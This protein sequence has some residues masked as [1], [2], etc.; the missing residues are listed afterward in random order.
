MRLQ[1]GMPY[2][3]IANIS[4]ELGGH[5]LGVIW[6]G[7]M[8]MGLAGDI[9]GRS[10]TKK[11]WAEIFWRAIHLSP[12]VDQGRSLLSL[13]MPIYHYPRYQESI[14]SQCMNDTGTSMKK[15]FLKFNL[16]L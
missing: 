9:F 13:N 7:N 2:M 12:S 15:F 10:S 16:D 1:Y 5:I 11:N 6:S 14:L 3:V 4:I 8:V